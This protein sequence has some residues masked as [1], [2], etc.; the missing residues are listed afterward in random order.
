MSSTI[1]QPTIKPPTQSQ[2]IG[3]Y[4]NIAYVRHQGEFVWKTEEPGRAFA[5]PYEIT[6]PENPAE[7]NRT[8]VFEPPHFTSGTVSRDAFLGTQLLFPLGFSHA[9]VGYSNLFMRILNR[10]PGFELVI[11]GKPVTILPPRPGQPGEV[12]DLNILQQFALALKQSSLFGPVERLY[13]MG[14]SDSGKTVHEVYKPFGHKLFDLSFACTAPYVA[15][16]KIAGQKP[17]IVFN[18]ERDFDPLAVPDPKFPQYRWYAVAG[19][20]HIPD[21]VL[22]RPE[23]PGGQGPIPPIAGTSPINWL[24]IIRALFLAGDQWIRNGTPP[25]ASVTL[26]VN[27]QGLIARDVMGNAL[28]G[29]RHPALETVEARF[30]SSVVREGWELFGGYGSPKRLTDAEYPQ[31]LNSFSKAADALVAARYLLPVGR[32]RLLKEVQLQRPNTFTLNYL[33]GL[34]IPDSGS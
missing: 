12:T 19:A 5:V 6:T 16:E 4:K 34:L 21:A 33:E 8:F 18:T 2:K 24:P 30:I 3:I 1:H 23:F 28:G 13:A 7:G 27:P 15:P 31:Y 11:K 20:P 10:D 9:S 14:F 25:P 17:I 32:D 26:K 22:T 29:I